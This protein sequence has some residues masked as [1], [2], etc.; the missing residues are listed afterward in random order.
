MNLR[1]LSERLVLIPVNELSLAGQ[2]QLL[3]IR[4]QPGIRKNMYSDHFIGADEHTRWL[5]RQACD[6]TV[7][8][9]GVELDGKLVGG[10]G[11]S[12]ISR[13]HARADWAFYLDESMQGQGLGSALGLR[14]LDFAFHDRELEKVNGEAIEFNT[15]SA[16]FHL[17][18]GFIVEG[19]R[20]RH[21]VRDGETY[22]AILFG[23][24]AGEWRESRARL[25]KGIF[26]A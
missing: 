10:V 9:C 21:V 14:F 15:S 1:L 2:A 22:D 23:I 3:S 12:A 4:N 8:F 26:L 24:T 11:L 25:E 6:Q 5:E 20:R 17:Q 16:R 18:M 13:V 7:E 19:K